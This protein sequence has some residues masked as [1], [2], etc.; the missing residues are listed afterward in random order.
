M[1]PAWGG[2]IPKEKEKRDLRD[3]EEVEM[4]GRAT[5][6]GARENERSKVVLE[7]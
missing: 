2:V 5:D 6:M 7:L 4:T 1:E 3:T